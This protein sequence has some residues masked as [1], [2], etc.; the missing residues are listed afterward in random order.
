MRNIWL[1]AVREFK[2]TAMT[3]AFVF[4]VVLL[5][6]I[7]YG[8][9]GGAFALGV[10]DEKEEPLVGT[11]AIVDATDDDRVAVAIERRFQP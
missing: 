3:K 9:L 1:T 5:P 6:V 11:V 7:F 4:G 2:A 8:L 10:F